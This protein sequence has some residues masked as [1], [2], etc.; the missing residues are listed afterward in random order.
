MRYTTLTASILIAVASAFGQGTTPTL[1]EQLTRLAAEYDAIEERFMKELRADRTQAGVSAANARNREAMKVWWEKSLDLIRRYPADP[2]AIPVIEKYLSG[3]SVD[4]VELVGVLRKHHMADPRL[5]R[6]VQSLYQ[7]DAESM[8][9]ALEIADRHPDRTT[10]ARACYAVG[11]IAKWQLIQK[12]NDRLGLIASDR[13]SAALRE[14]KERALRSHAEKYLGKAAKEY[15]DAAL[16][17]GDEKVGPLA[18]AALAG[19][20]NLDNLKVGKSAPE[21][22]GT[23]L[24]GAKLKL[25]DQRGKVVLVVFWASWCGPC[26]ADVPHERELY[27]KLKGRPFTILGVNGD[28]EVAKAKQAVDRAKIAWPSFAPDSGRRSDIPSAW[29]V[30][31]WPTTYVIDHQGIIRH[32]NLQGDKLDQPLAELVKA[33]EQAKASER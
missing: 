24:S 1:T 22:D 17:T 26:M 16:E 29:N 4:N 7:S 19:M 5:A 8:N 13:F 25:S 2:T 18:L 20:A 9:L 14:D 11:W 30:F 32:I 27:E 12:A 23:D 6:L 3:N 21:I 28:E 15:P 33:A 10:R 31:S